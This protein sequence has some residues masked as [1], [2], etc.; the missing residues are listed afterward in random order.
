MLANHLIVALGAILLV[1]WFR[2][3][4]SLALNAKREP[5][6][7]ARVAAANGLTFLVVQTKLRTGG[8]ALDE[9]SASLDADYQILRHLLRHAPG[10]GLA[11]F[12]QRMLIW[13]YHIMSIWY[14]LV[15]RAWDEQARKALDE[16]ARIVSYLAQRMA[17]RAAVYS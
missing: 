11:T 9:L 13:D 10:R 8:T 6:C 14:R 17:Q 15:A 7:L 3:A 2:Y 1:Y 5:N 4:C 16:R 12:E